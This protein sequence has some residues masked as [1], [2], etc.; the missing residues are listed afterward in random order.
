V[1]TALTP[2][3]FARRARRLFGDK[4]AVV[5]GELRLTYEQFFQ[6]CDRWSAALQVLGVRQGDRVAYIAPNTHS[7][8]ESFYAV[9]QIG[10]VVV[11][12]N[13]RLT[14]DDFAYIINH[15]G[16]KIVCAH[17]DYLELVDGIRDQIPNVEHFVALEGERDG[18]LD[19][20]AT[21]GGSDGRFERPEINE[22]DLLSINYT[23]GTTSRPKGVMITHRNAYMNVVGTLI[24]VHMTPGDRYLWTLPMFHANGWTFVWI[25]TAVGGT[26]VCLRRVMPDQV[27]ATV[28]SEQ[29]SMFCAAPTVL[30]GIANAPPEL[31]QGAPRGLRVLTAGA[32][33]AA[34]TIARMEGDLGWE[35]TQVY[36]LTETA[37]FIT[38]CEPRPEHAGLSPNDLATIKARQGVELITSGELMVMDDDGN[39]VPHDGETLGEIVVRGNVVMKGY[40]ND[41]DATATAFRGGWFHSGDAAVVHPDGYAEIRDR[42]KDVIISGGENI[43][44]VEV[45]GIIMR[46]PVVQE[47]AVVGLADERWGEAPHAFVVLRPGA[48]ATDDELRQFARD[49]MAHFKVPKSFNFVEELPKTAT[50]KIQKYVL[51][52][53][54]AAIARQ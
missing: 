36:G 28:V 44:S 25:V 29:I 6:R 42:L 39:E 16:S 51:R 34:A 52:G 41:P 49:N 22:S 53:G 48:S 24:H 45:E 33:P 13:Y 27:F 20:E 4:E 11:P 12:I 50:G 14:A 31:R 40:Y 38:V 54:Q 18:W 46:H 26:H 21:L 15:S 3:E 7:Q 5:D 9:P 8:L 37:P 1:E 35:I 47:V 43:S 23:S 32:P 30:I 10:A 2:M 19:Y 17:A